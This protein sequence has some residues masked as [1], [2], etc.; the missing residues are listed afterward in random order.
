MTQI[1]RSE[2]SFILQAMLSMAAAD[3]DL[4]DNEL[5]TIRTV[6]ERITGEMVTV[7]DIKIAPHGDQAQGLAFAGQLAVAR[8]QLTRELKE[9]ILSSAYMVL[10]ADGRVA[11]RERKMLMDF[12]TALKISEVQRSIIFEDVERALH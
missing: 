6:Y 4:H 12:V 7:D 3:G 9:T 11:A 2:R 1:Q 5:A 8:D 10:L